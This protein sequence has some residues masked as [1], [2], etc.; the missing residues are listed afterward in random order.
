M[1]HTSDI[2]HLHKE[3]TLPLVVA[4][5]GHRD[6]VASEL[7]SIRAT[8][9]SFLLDLQKRFPSNRLTIMSPLAEGADQLVAEVAVELDI[10]LIVPLPKPRQ[11]YIKDFELTEVRDRFEFL[12]AKASQV[13]EICGEIPPVP[14]G[15]DPTKWENDYP[16]AQLG[17]YLC[18]HCHI[19]L[20]L[21]DGRP[22][23]RMGGTA[24]I[25]KFHHDDTMVDVTGMTVSSQELLVDDE[26]DLVFHIVCSRR[27][28]PSKLGLDL[29]PLDWWWYTK[30]HVEPRSK[31]L[32]QQHALIFQRTSDFSTD[33]LIHAEKIETEKW[34]L[35]EAENEAAVPAGAR[36]ID[37][38]YT[39]ADWLAIHFQKKTL[40]TLAITH[41]MGF[42][43]GFMF[44]LYS[45]MG[46][47]R[48][49]LWIFLIA[50]ASGII[51]QYL[52]NR[53]AWQRKYL[54][55]RTLA[56]GL[57]VQFYWAVAGVT[58]ENKW[59]FAHDGYLKS[60][61]PEIG[62]IRNVMRVAG[63]RSDANPNT[64]VAGVNFTINEW[65]G[66]EEQGQLGYFK[67][68]SAERIQRAKLTDNFG[69]ASL[70]VSVSAVLLFLI[71]GSRIGEF[72]ESIVMVTLG[73]T[74]LIYG[75]R[76]GYTFA[77]G[78]KELIRQYEFML[79]IFDNS[80]IRLT[81]AKD[82]KE[83]RQILAALGQSALDEHSDWILMNR[84]RSIDEVEVWRMGM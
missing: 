35:I 12:C 2:H 25:V 42:L 39:T 37:E 18:G 80:F 20:A 44:I 70:L 16:Y 36:I 27:S 62:W 73:S 38:M 52:A 9:K 43:M 33:A 64:N 58:N 45:D 49:F 59:K 28:E 15:I 53:G 65:V 1:Q 7:D 84:E 83:K 76:E 23:D 78:T 66:N 55:Y 63:I 19:L 51:S 22:S 31:D 81:S 17:I 11:E 67:R 3:Y 10:D 13:F 82:I 77:T 40:R 56:E 72:W 30:D 4:I 41:I 29:K 46:T 68:K 6:L 71:V 21:W 79:R 34:S 54:D 8:T 69:R 75:V 14:K 5:T 57:R 24:Q 47:W 61:N 32:P 26:S 50:F 60:Q 74:L 48:A